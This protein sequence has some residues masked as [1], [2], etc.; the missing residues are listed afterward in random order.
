[1][2][3]IISHFTTVYVVTFPLPYLFC[4][5]SKWLHIWFIVVL[6]LVHNLIEIL[7]I[8]INGKLLFSTFNSLSRPV[9]IYIHSTSKDSWHIASASDFW[10]SLPGFAPRCVL[11]TKPSI[12]VWGDWRL[13]VI[14][15]IFGGRLY[16]LPLDGAS[17]PRNQLSC[18]ECETG[19]GGRPPN[20]RQHDVEQH[21]GLVAP[22][23][24]RRRNTSLR[25]NQ[26]AMT[27][28]EALNRN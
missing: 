28:W 3:P 4:L 1:M 20:Q 11:P 27:G 9:P 5:N 12:N 25:K 2:R 13:S 7:E 16:W 8:L 23:S 19:K 17:G 18:Y 10:S 26:S 22:S 21:K 14:Q 15:A 24:T 6:C